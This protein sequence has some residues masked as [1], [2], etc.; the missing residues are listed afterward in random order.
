[1]INAH[2]PDLTDVYAAS[3]ARYDTMSYRR[4]GRSGVRLP[5]LT[6]GLWNNFDG[7]K[8]FETARAMIR[9]AFDK[10]ITHFDLANNYG[11]P[12]GSAERVFG[13]IF[14]QDLIPYRD[15]LFISSKAGYD[16][17]PGPYGDHG[18]RKYLIASVNQSLKRTGLDY[19]DVF[20]HH[21]PD[22]DTP[23]E[24]TMGALDQIVRSGK[25]L[26]AGLSNYP[27]AE[28]AQAAEIM[29]R[30]GTPLLIHQPSYSILNRWTEEDRLFD[31]T[32]ENGMGVIV[33]SPLQRGLLSSRYLDSVP[34]DS[35]GARGHRLNKAFVTDETRG[36][37]RQL[38]EIASDRGQTLSEM[39]LAWTLK[40]DRV[41][42]ALFGAS[43]VAQVAENLKAIE[44]LDFSKEELDRIDQAA[45]PFIAYLNA[46]A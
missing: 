22:P 12:Y 23:L 40:D 4:C 13:Q 5:L 45:A 44:R 29:R 37:M 2:F 38:N 17:W 18:S 10:G 3:P 16:M 41:T 28:T 31:T 6:L 15:E 35:R 24:E 32:A 46:H 7:Y 42:S 33:F 39:A 34:A 27:A 21:R 26:Y 9:F 11:P 14:A 20:Y 43:S 1:M 36:Y 25:A 8:S 19:F 30:L